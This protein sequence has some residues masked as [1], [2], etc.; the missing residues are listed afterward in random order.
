MA[1]TSP[2][3]TVGDLGLLGLRR[4]L[5][6]MRGDAREQ[7][8]V[9]AGFLEM[10]ERLHHIFH[11]A[12]G[13]PLAGFDDA[14]LRLERKVARILRMGAVDEIGQGLPHAARAVEQAYR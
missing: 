11:I 13:L 6:K 7:R 12:A 1:G 2:A 3:M 14:D 9:H 5:S 4:K 8:I 10:P